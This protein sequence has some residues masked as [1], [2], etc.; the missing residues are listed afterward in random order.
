MNKY[1]YKFFSASQSEQAELWKNQKFAEGFDHAYE[2]KSIFGPDK[3]QT[4]I[5]VS[6]G[7]LSDSESDR[8]FEQ[9]Q[10]VDDAEEESFEDM[11]RRLAASGNLHIR[12]TDGDDSDD[13]FNDFDDDDDFDDEDDEEDIDFDEDED[14]EDD[15]DDM[16]EHYLAEKSDSSTHSSLRAS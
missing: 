16:L 3:G 4:R 13:D 7:E 15:E 1:E 8:I 10:G 12:H 9:N 2:Q 11:L 6:K 14:F 5:I